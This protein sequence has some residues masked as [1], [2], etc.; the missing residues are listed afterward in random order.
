MVVLLVGLQVLGQVVDPFSQKGDLHLGRT[1][2][3]LMLGILL[4]NSVLFFL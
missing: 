1:G 3:P 2:I 4:D